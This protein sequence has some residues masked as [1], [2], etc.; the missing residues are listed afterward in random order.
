MSLDYSNHL[1]TFLVPNKKPEPPK[2]NTAA[3][4]TLAITATLALELT[5]TI[6]LGL[7]REPGHTFE[8]PYQLGHD[9]RPDP[10]VINPNTRL[11]IGDCYGCSVEGANFRADPS[12]DA[13][14]IKGA[15]LR[16]EWV[17]LTGATV[18][19]DGIVWYEV[20]NESPLAHAIEAV[21]YMP[22]AHQ[23]GWIAGCFVE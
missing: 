6:N 23:Y 9:N 20:I 17:V 10:D 19:R 13:S 22:P 15:V 12:M 18:Y 7:F 14:V 3:T 4:V 1:E 2:S 11:Q 21:H 5:G 8:D 16:G